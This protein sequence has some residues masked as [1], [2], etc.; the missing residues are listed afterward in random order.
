MSE[1]S[2]VAGG[3]V[4]LEKVT[5]PQQTVWCVNTQDAEEQMFSKN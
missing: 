4:G 2:P 1:L 3:L 5:H